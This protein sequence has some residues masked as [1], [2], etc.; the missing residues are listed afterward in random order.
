MF[1]SNNFLVKTLVKST[2]RFINLENSLVEMPEISREVQ[3]E[4]RLFVMAIMAKNLHS[5]SDQ[6]DN[7]SV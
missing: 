3:L 5:K 1:S 4:R 6:D 7:L 2:A